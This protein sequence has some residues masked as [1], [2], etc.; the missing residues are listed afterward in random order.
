MSLELG[1]GIT[2]GPGVRID[3]VLEPVT[4]GLQLYLDE[5]GRAHV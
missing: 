3:P 1:P 5:I 4:D 2:F